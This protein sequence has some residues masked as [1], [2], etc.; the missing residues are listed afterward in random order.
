M[1]R[2]DGVEE[3][4]VSEPQ[5]DETPRLRRRNAFAWAAI[6]ATIVLQYGLFREFALREVVWAYPA[7]HDQTQFLTD[8]YDIYEQILDKGLVHGLGYALHLPVPQGIILHVQASL[9]Y[10]VMGPGRLS[11]LTLNF[12]YFALLQAVL[13]WTLRWLSGRWSMAL[14]GLGLLLCALTPFFWAGGLMDFRADFAAMCLFGVLLCLAIRSGLFVSRPWSAVVAA[15]AA[16]LILFRIITVVF[17]GG[18]LGLFVA[19][20]VVRLCWLRRDAGLRRTE[21]RRLA[22]IVLASAIVGLLTVPVLWQQ[23]HLLK[24]Y[25]IKGHGASEESRIRM[26]E[27]GRALGYYPPVL[28]R[29]QAG[30][31]FVKLAVLALLSAALL[32]WLRRSAPTRAGEEGGGPIRRYRWAWIAVLAAGILAYLAVNATED[33]TPRMWW[34]SASLVLV[35][36][37]LGLSR[38]WG[39]GR[40][41]TVGSLPAGPVFVFLALSFVLPVVVLTIDLHRSPVVVSVAIPP[42]LLLVFAAVAWFAGIGPREER[43]L[44]EAGLRALAAVAVMTAGWLQLSQYSQRWKM[45]RNRQDVEEVIR[46]HDAIGTACQEYDIRA[47]MVA[48]TTNPDYLPGRITS[49]LNYER[50]GV[51]RHISSILGGHYNVTEAEAMLAVQ[52]CNFAIITRPDTVTTPFGQ[53]MLKWM[54]QLRQY[55][56]QHLV[57]LGRF[58]IF[59]DDVLLYVRKLWTEGDNGGWITSAGFKIKAPGCELRSGKVQLWG[60]M[61]GPWQDGLPLPRAM[62]SISG[63][64]PRMLPAKIALEGSLYVLTVDCT[65]AVVSS[66]ADAELHLTFDRHFVPKERGINEDTRKLVL[67]TPMEVLIVP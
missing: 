25:Y 3:R 17:L 58:H 24:S 5:Q 7:A 12:L 67:P 15:A 56:D 10:L 32:S 40:T 21:W 39:R 6:A 53:S 57:R 45:T 48:L 60:K 2:P 65:N 27:T 50:Q 22:N 4:E 29:E 38:R 47:P 11:A 54:P 34:S 18:I 37:G 20:L 52:R 1:S 16:Y 42:L 35:A 59:G 14:A 66:D 30:P 51:F 43:P 19:F 49:V 61:M 55:C 23:R 13:V 9:F 26:L 36:L 41:A 31:V 28:L 62:L 64:S 8:S 46:L 33:D 44:P 63:Q